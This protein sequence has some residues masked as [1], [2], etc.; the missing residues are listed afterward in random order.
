MTSSSTD[1]DDCMLRSSF[2]RRDCGRMMNSQKSSTMP[3]S[4]KNST[5]KGPLR[6]EDRGVGARQGRPTGKCNQRGGL[7]HEPGVD[8]TTA[9]TSLLEERAVR[10]RGAWRGE[11]EVV[12]RGRGGDPAP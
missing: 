1:N 12:P 7:H 11:P 8:G 9:R 2:W 6:A 10:V 5:T 3:T 4:G